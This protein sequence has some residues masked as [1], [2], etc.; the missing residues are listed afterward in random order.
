MTWSGLRISTSPTVWMSP[1]SDGARTLLAHDH[2]LG[3][4]AFHLDGD[5]LDVEHDVGDVLAHAGDRGEFMQHAVD[6]HGGHGGAAQR[7]QQHA[8]QRVAERQAEA[9]LERLGDQRGHASSS[10][11]RTRSCSA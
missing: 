4:V 1:A 3:A 5:F 11:T 8:A 7:R 10:S 9:A 2:A 6:L